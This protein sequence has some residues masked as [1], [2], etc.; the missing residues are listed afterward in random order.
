MVS[1]LLSGLTVLKSKKETTKSNFISSHST[2]KPVALFGRKIM[3]DLIMT[4]SVN[5]LEVQ[6]F[7]RLS[8]SLSSSIFAIQYYRI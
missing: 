1:D 3:I 2:Q 8:F 7:P 5:F 6:T 4:Y